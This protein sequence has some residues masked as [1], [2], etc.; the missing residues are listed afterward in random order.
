[1]MTI[2]LDTVFWPFLGKG[3]QSSAMWRQTSLLKHVQEYTEADSRASNLTDSSVI[4]TEMIFQLR[5]T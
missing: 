4:S 3:E 1:M 2:Q 5:T